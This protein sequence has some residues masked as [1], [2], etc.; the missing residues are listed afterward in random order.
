MS[1]QGSCMIATGSN[2]RYCSCSSCSCW[3]AFHDMSSSSRG[4][5]ILPLNAHSFSLLYYTRCTRLYTCIVSLYEVSPPSS[6]SFTSSHLNI[7]QRTASTAFSLYMILLLFL[8]Q[9]FR[10]IMLLI[11]SAGAIPKI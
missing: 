3:V 1:V 8:T 11:F 10:H 7:R 9:H 5:I 2:R 6:S 4:F